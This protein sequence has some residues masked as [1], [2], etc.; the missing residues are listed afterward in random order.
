MKP[1]ILGVLVQN[2][3]LGNLVEL[4]YSNPVEKYSLR[5]GTLCLIVAIPLIYFEKYR[6]LGGWL[7]LVAAILF[8]AYSLAS[9]LWNLRFILT[10]TK[11]YI[12]DLSKR[13]E[14]E[15]ALI[16]KLAAED[17]EELDSLL[18]RLEFERQRLTSRIG[19]IVG[20]VD[21][22]GIIPAIIALYLTYAKTMNDANLSKVPYPVLGFIS[23]IYVGCFLLKQ[24]IDRFEHMCLVVESAHVRA[25]TR[26]KLSALTAESKGMPNQAQQR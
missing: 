22:L 11:S 21:K 9:F 25:K 12:K 2:D 17:H 19:F 24:V 1:H 26:Y 5:I 23:G 8:I 15:E 4:L 14:T 3:K 20:A 7:C 16:N 13:I 10:P 18:K 6:L